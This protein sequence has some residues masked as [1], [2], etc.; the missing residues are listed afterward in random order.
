MLPYI[1]TPSC[2]LPADTLGLDRWRPVGDADLVGRREIW[3]PRDLK[4]KINAGKPITNESTESAYKRYTDVRSFLTRFIIGD[5]MSIGAGADRCDIKIMECS[6]GSAFDTW[7]LRII[8]SSPHT[9]IFGVFVSRQ[10]FLAMGCWAKREMAANGPM[11]QNN[12][13]VTCRNKANAL[14]KG[15]IL[16][17]R[18]RPSWRD[19]GGLDYG[20]YPE[21][22]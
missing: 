19:L 11:S 22:Y 7:E 17:H 16:F 13:S 4:E 6:P 2:L 21:E 5:D 10:D 9:R 20:Y 3:L 1:S 15:Q 12:L 8:P 14:L 18:M